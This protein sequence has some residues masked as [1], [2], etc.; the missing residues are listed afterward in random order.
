[1]VDLILIMRYHIAINRR[2]GYRIVPD[3]FAKLVELKGASIKR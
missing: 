2:F 1:M 3:Y